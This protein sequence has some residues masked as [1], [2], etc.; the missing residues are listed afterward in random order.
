MRRFAIAPDRIVAG[1]IAFDPLESRH[2]SRA[3]RLR[4]G[5]TVVASDGA[6]HEYTVRLDE[7]GARA[8]GTVLGSA[9]PTLTESPLA[10][11]LLQ[12]VPKGD[13]MDGIVRAATELGVVR[14]QPVLTARTV[15]RLTASAAAQR[16]QRWQRVAREAAKQCGRAVVPEVGT[17]APLASCLEAAGAD[18]LAI[19]F[20]EAGAPPL[21]GVLQDAGAPRRARVLIGPEGGLDPDEV[22]RARG[23]GWRIAGLGARILRTETAAPA[24]LAILQSRFGDVG[25]DAGR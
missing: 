15:V 9:R 6:G 3:L 24:V 22:E 4:P 20:W 2:L 12:G 10:V 8:I 17:P 21:A 16:A 5:D 23:A 7:V 1:R 13:K 14:I 25:R 19:C 18:E 11:T